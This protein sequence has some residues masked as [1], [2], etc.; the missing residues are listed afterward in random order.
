M[1]HLTLPVVILTAILILVMTALSFAQFEEVSHAERKLVLGG[2]FND[3]QYSI[4][5]TAILPVRRGDFSG[6]AGGYVNKLE[7]DWQI[8]TRLE[9]GVA[10]LKT[11]WTLNLFTEYGRDDQNGVGSQVAFGFFGE[12][13][14]FAIGEASIT[15]GLGN[16]VENQQAR[17]DLGLK[18]T[19]DRSVRLLAYTAL[20]YRWIS[21]LT[22]I[23]PN[24]KVWDDARDF[25][26]V[27]QPTIAFNDNVSL[28]T[29]FEYDSQPVIAGDT[30][31]ISGGVQI[32]IGF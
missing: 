21:I 6:W 3:E 29:Q 19:A 2:Q 10:V 30:V 24:A 22:K 8:V 32:A 28:V 12:S 25:Q 23:T 1:D 15:A 4:N 5:G 11:D 7:N 27:V 13:P 16:Y 31:N 14:R 26:L 17:D 18:D 9:G 20:R